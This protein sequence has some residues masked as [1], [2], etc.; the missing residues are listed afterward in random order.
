MFEKIKKKVI[1]IPTILI[2]IVLPINLIFYFKVQI[3]FYKEKYISKND[4][5]RFKKISKK[6][7]K[8]VIPILTILITIV[9]RSFLNLWFLK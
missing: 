8:K 9:L 3:I 4:F 5:W 7:K 2:T 6:I 1:P